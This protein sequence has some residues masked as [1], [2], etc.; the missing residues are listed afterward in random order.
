MVGR[1]CVGAGVFVCTYTVIMCMN[2]WLCKHACFHHIY[3]FSVCLHVR[4]FWGG[5]SCVCVEAKVANLGLSFG[6]RLLGQRLWRI[7]CSAPFPH[8]WYSLSSFL[9]DTHPPAPPS[10]KTPT[11][12]PPVFFFIQSWLIRC[13][14]LIA[15]KGKTACIS[16]RG[17]ESGLMIYNTWAPFIGTEWK[18]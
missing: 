7:A 13:T 1:A 5:P 4:M 14:A 16:K 10:P 12:K 8:W 17:D 11:Q 15:F 18:V 6:T 3:M 9:S 2:V